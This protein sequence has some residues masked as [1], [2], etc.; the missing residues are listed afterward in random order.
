MADSYWEEYLRDNLEEWA[1][2]T[3]QKW[4]ELRKIVWI[5]SG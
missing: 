1:R 2:D 5:R 4:C 3:E